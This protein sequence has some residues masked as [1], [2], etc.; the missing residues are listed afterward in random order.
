MRNTTEHPDHEKL[1]TRESFS[2]WRWWIA[3]MLFLAAILNYIDRQTLSILAPTIQKDLGLSEADYGNIASLFL[4]AYTVSLLATGRLVDR[5]G[6]RWGMAMFIT[7]WS[8]AN[9]LTGL[10]RSFFS[11]GI[12]RFLLGLGEAGNWPAS[13]KAVGQCFPASQR[14]VAIGFY[15]MGAT[16][17]ATIAPVLVIAL[18]ARYGWQG[19]FVATGALGLLWV[20]PWLWLYRRVEQPSGRSSQESAAAAK[21]EDFE[22]APPT[23]MSEWRCW[24]LVL[25]RRDVWLL[26]VGRMLTDPVWFFYQFWFAKYLFADRGVP[27]ESLGMTWV[28]FLAADLGSLG[29]GFLSAG[30]IRRGTSAPA[31][32]LWAMLLCAA[33]LPLSPLVALAPSVNMAMAFAM[34]GVLAHLAW[35][36]NISALLVDLI[37]QRLVATAFG[38]V[39]AG[40]ALGGMAMN[41][42]VVY[43]VKNYSYDYWF[44]I[45]AGLHPL[46][47]LILWAFRVHRVRNDLSA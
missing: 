21:A 24:R 38:V 39:A 31:A 16:I 14:G 30:L 6:A 45:M 47:W 12:C 11:L 35:L 4:M 20:M 34:L 25:K 33:V 18:A 41:E 46:A 3:G 26:L 8:C 1:A 22:D 10:A 7:W 15:T 5:L 2:S 43:L 29:G 37:P 17:G 36:A 32:R 9:M 13:A 40:S 19:A 28:I 27:Q 44:F 42:I 23:K